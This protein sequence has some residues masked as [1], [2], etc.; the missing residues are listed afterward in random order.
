M[1][2]SRSWILGSMSGR[3]IRPSSFA[4][5]RSVNSI[6]SI[7]GLD[8]ALENAE[9]LAGEVVDSITSLTSERSVKHVSA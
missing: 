7:N 5:R 2:I 8:G 6:R 4:G 3:P 1:L 9:R